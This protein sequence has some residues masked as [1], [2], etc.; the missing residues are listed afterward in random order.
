MARTWKEGG[1]KQGMF[2][3]LW[4]DPGVRAKRVDKLTLH[5]DDRFLGHCDRVLSTLDGLST[6]ESQFRAA[7]NSDNEFK[8]YLI[9]LNPDFKNGFNDRLSR[10]HLQ[11]LLKTH[12]HKRA[13]TD[14][15]RSWLL[16]HTD[17]ESIVRFCLDHGRDVTRIDVMRRFDLTRAELEEVML[18][19]GG[20]KQ[21]ASTYLKRKNHKVVRVERLV[22]RE[23]TGCI[24]VEDVHNFATAGSI[25][26]YTSGELARLE[27]GVFIKNSVDEDYIIPVR[28]KESGTKI[29]TLAGGQNTA[30]VEDVEYIQKKLFAALKIPRA[31][32]GYDEMLSSKATLA[33][34]DIRFSRTIGIIQK[35][36]I[37]EL[38]KIAVIHLFAHGFSDDDLLDFTLRLSNPSTVAQQQKLE[39]W[40][41][42]FEIAGSAPEGMVDK[43]FI[44]REILGL[45]EEQC[46]SA[47]KNRL[48]EK[49]IDQAIDSAEP[50]EDGGGGGGG[51]GGSLFGGGGGGGAPAAGGDDDLGGD[52]GDAGAAGEGGGDAESPEPA[53][54]PADV[55]AS[56]DADEEKDSELELLTSIDDP[57]AS[58]GGPPLRVP[59]GKIDAPITVKSHMK[60]YAQNQA[61]H[62]THG[63]SK[64]HMPDFE[65][66]LGSSNKSF[67]DPYDLRSMNAIVSDPLG[68]ARSRRRGLPQ[69]TRAMLEQMA[70]RLDMMA[71]RSV[72][73]V[74]AEAGGR[75]VQH[76]IERGIPFSDDVPTLEEQ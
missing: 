10:G 58:D 40:R 31:Y 26:C 49:L 72:D 71:V 66:M 52:L 2:V 8:A 22:H 53:E 25:D 29:D 1:I 33:Q 5:V 42:R 30:A 21:F 37:A 63:A 12:G 20:Y 60:R 6:K 47:D 3:E 41:A 50:A 46:K 75:D 48:E 28:G 36:I 74:I 51:G 7:L 4:R 34:E 62:R 11:A 56:D 54:E 19:A 38:N 68:E 16:R 9:A 18:S 65:R 59:L 32:L 24:T 76:E 27:T 39:L 23:D 70:K 45:T 43:H 44:R 67:A 61:R 35:T 17:V 69:D 55:N 14:L 57:E 15:K 73:G 64:T 13:F